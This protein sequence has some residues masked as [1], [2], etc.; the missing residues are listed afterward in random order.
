R[1]RP[2]DP[3]CLPVR[4]LTDLASEITITGQILRAEDRLVLDFLAGLSILIYV[5][6]PDR[7]DV[8]VQ[9]SALWYEVLRNRL[10]LQL[11]N[12][13][14]LVKV[15]TPL[16]AQVYATRMLETFL[17]SSPEEAT[18]FF[19]SD[20]SAIGRAVALYDPATDL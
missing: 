7:A 14:A 6:H 3:A 2:D 19:A 1:W 17:F 5:N 10:K 11:L 18:R 4:L 8:V 12:R 9:T 16:V 20:R 13:K 15:A